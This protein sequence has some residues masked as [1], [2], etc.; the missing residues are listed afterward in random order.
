M[1]LNLLNESRNLRVLYHGT[2]VKNLPSIMSVGLEPTRSNWVEDEYSNGLSRKRAAAFVYLSESLRGAEAFS[3]GGAYASNSN[4]EEQAILEIRLPLKLRA[5][6][7]TNIGEFV[8][9]PFTIPPQFIKR[10][11]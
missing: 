11:K 3:P 6:L 7:V 2:D 5:K 1:K 8:R 9:A 4:L 10:I